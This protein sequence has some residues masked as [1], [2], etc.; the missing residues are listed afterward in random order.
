MRYAIFVFLLITIPNNLE[1]QQIFF[2]LL[3]KPDNELWQI[4]LK[5]IKKQ[6]LVSSVYMGNRNLEEHLRL[7]TQINSKKK[8][9]FIAMDVKKREKFGLFVGVFK[10][11]KPEGKIARIDEIPYVHFELSNKIAESIAASYNK[12]VVKLPLFPMLGVD[13]PA[14]Y[15]KISGEKRDIEKLA[16]DINEVIRKYAVE[17]NFYE[18][19]W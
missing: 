13:M 15:I 4:F 11:K 17:D 14:I 6:G 1:A 2:Y 16:G 12:R 19:R 7:I 8:G 10:P 3:D 9:L 18:T 5:T